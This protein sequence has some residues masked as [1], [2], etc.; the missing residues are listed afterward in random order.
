MLP[1]QNWE[2]FQCG[3][4]GKDAVMSKEKSSKM[5]YQ[6][7]PE[8]SSQK[9]RSQRCKQMI[10]GFPPNNFRNFI[11][12]YENIWLAFWLY[13]KGKRG[14]GS[15]M[16]RRIIRV[17]ACFF[18]SPTTV[19]QSHLIWVQFSL[20]HWLTYKTITCERRP[21][22]KTAGQSMHRSSQT[23]QAPVDMYC[24]TPLGIHGRF[25]TLLPR[26]QAHNESPAQI[27][28]W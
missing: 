19:G 2:Y 8:V 12:S 10:K 3:I 22:T 13:R 18:K 5:H 23:M 15:F 11:I 16:A 24:T 14:S 20:I 17:R 9:H 27:Y 28:R 21:T 4:T 25:R 1:N 6:K 7:V 26:S